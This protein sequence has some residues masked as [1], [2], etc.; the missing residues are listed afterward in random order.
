MC[1]GRRLQSIAAT[2]DT[3]ISELRTLFFFHCF[4]ERCSSFKSVQNAGENISLEAGQIVGQWYQ[5]DA[6]LFR[7]ASDEVLVNDGITT[8]KSSRIT[9]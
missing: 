1:V 3:R 5:V 9:Q 2:S 4:E 6:K 8:A 7:D